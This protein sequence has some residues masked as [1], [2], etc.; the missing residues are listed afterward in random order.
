MHL[1]KYKI[2]AA[3]LAV[4][5]LLP[6][7]C[8]CA[9]DTVVTR[10][11][12]E[13]SDPAARDDEP[14]LALNFEKTSVASGKSFVLIATPVPFTENGASYTYSFS[15][16]DESIASVDENGVV[17]G[18]G[19]GVCAVTV[20]CNETGLTAE[21]AVYV[22]R[23]VEPDPT[24]TTT[25]EESETPTE[26]ETST[27]T[28]DVIPIEKLKISGPHKVVVG[29]TAQYTVKVTPKNA[30]EHYT[31]HNSNTRFSEMTEDGLLTVTG[32]GTTTITV[33]TDDR[34]LVDSITVSLIPILTFDPDAPITVEVGHS[35]VLHAVV[36]PEGIDNKGV[37]W[38]VDEKNST[39]ELK[40][41][42]K[43]YNCTVTGVS[44]GTVRV[45]ISSKDHPSVTA[46]LDVTVTG[47]EAPYIELKKTS[48]ELKENES[49][50]I[51]ASPKFFEGPLSY[52]SADPS[53]ATVTQDG[54][55]RSVGEGETV[56]T[57]TGNDGTI[58]AECKVTVT[59]SKPKIVLSTDSVELSEGESVSSPATLK[60]AEGTL[61]YTSSAPE[62]A[63]VD[64]NGRITAVSKG[65]ATITI[66]FEGAESVTL[67]VTVTAADQPTEPDTP[68]PP[69]ETPEEQSG[70][71]DD[72]PDDI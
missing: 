9:F 48:I 71:N 50:S 39:G 41:E 64:E 32:I 37:S 65:T 16:S 72:A 61:V 14:R 70:G 60:N 19:E 53:V 25:T 38:K 26:S 12:E 35:A 31:I 67:S 40:L 55:V 46:S 22:D 47:G 66:S 18:N 68:T 1:T 34:R 23:V 17:T 36:L 24:T 21:C 5:T 45:V 54:I 29:E 59:I 56:I 58:S 11:P 27:D 44:A 69:D 51:G 30:T 20:T 10:T 42:A 8:A 43:K 63:K 4:L 3:L 7:F 15:S 33:E 52:V 57:I 28:G 49:E 2:L 13:I 62:V 6:L